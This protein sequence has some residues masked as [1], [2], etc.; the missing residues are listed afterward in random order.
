MASKEKSKEVASAAGKKM[1]DGV[2][3]LEKF[4]LTLRYEVEMLMTSSF[5]KACES[6]QINLEISFHCNLLL[7]SIL[8]HGTNIIDFICG[9]DREPSVCSP[10]KQ[11]VEKTG[12]DRLRQELLDCGLRDPS[13]GSFV[14]FRDLRHSRVAHLGVRPADADKKLSYGE[15][16][17]IGRQLLAS[18]FKCLASSKEFKESFAWFDRLKLDFENYSKE[19]TTDSKYIDTISGRVLVGSSAPQGGSAIFDIS[20]SRLSV[21]G[22]KS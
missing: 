19:A 8:I 6:V 20:L 1:V 18:F 15:A 11:M 17:K 12:Y 13:D 5:P 14:P 7:E 22:Q 3:G 21:S 2:D 16:S 10:F 9:F 4:Y